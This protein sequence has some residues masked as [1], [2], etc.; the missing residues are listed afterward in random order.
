LALTLTIRKNKEGLVAILRRY[1][2][3]RL[4]LISEETRP[5]LLIVVNILLQDLDPGCKLNADPD[6]KHW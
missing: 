4:I 6:P 2:M 1:R 5:H 3:G